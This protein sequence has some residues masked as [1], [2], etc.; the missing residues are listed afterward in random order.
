M[1]EE[2]YAEFLPQGFCRRQ[3]TIY[4]NFNPKIELIFLEFDI[5]K[6]TLNF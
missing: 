3:I 4:L 1:G 6:F 5:G 2:E